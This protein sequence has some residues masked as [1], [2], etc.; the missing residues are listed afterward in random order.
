MFDKI[1]TV[2]HKAAKINVLI[3]LLLGCIGFA[4][5]ILKW[6]ESQL[7]GFSGGIG[8]ID[9][10]FNYSCDQVYQMLKSYNGEGREFYAIIELTADMVY[11]VIYSLFLSLLIIFLFKRLYIHER[12]VKIAFLMPI[13]TL[14]ADFFENI[15]I[16]FMLLNYPYKLNTI[17]EAAN[18]FTMIRWVFLAASLLLVLTAFLLL[19]A[20]FIKDKFSYKSR[21][22][23]R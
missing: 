22:V 20:R 3:F 16:T 17:A 2:Y 12:V 8:P 7:K 19:V 11:P 4:V 21:T 13:I 23:S 9:L 10:L 6:A 5:F 15:C 1:Y 14:A 18:I